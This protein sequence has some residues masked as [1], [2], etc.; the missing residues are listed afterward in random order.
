MIRWE[1][2]PL[3]K[4]AHRIQNIGKVMA[5]EVSISGYKDCSYD[6]WFIDDLISVKDALGIIGGVWCGMMS[7]MGPTMIVVALRL[8]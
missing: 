8:V 4:G 3:K 6:E 1:R 2:L 7:D 5:S